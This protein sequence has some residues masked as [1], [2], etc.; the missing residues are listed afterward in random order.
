MPV[1]TVAMLQNLVTA[2][3]RSP[4]PDALSS[5][6][7]APPPEASSPE[8]VAL[9]AVQNTFNVTVHITGGLADENELGERI[10]RLLID[11]AR[12]HGIDVA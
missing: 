4:R 5:A 9:P 7:E 1:T 2:W 8:K 10:A 11:Q 12:R 6:T 3:S